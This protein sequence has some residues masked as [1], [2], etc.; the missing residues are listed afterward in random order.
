MNP[1]VTVRTVVVDYNI[2]FV[3]GLLAETA[4]PQ[5]VSPVRYMVLMVGARTKYSVVKEFQSRLRSEERRV[6]KECVP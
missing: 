3:E 5:L 1:D 2:S 4:E 6:G